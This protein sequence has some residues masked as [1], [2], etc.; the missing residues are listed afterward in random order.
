[1][2][3]GN[4][5][6][7]TVDQWRGDCLS[8]L[9]HP[10]VETPNLDRLAAG[11]TVFANHWAQSAPCGPSRAC[12]YT[13]TYSMTN[14]VL[15][16]GTPLDARFTNLAVEARAGGYDPVLVG[17]TD[18]S[19]DPRGLAPDDPRLFS[20]E[21][22]LPGFEAVVDLRSQTLRPWIGWLVELGYERPADVADIYAADPTVA[23]AA[24]HGP[25]WAPPVYRAEHSDTAFL[26]DGLMEWLAARSGVDPL[27]RPPQLPATPSAVPGAGAVPRSL[28]SRG[29]GL[30]GSST[31]T[32]PGAVAP[33]V[34]HGPRRARH[35][36]PRR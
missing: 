32:R 18:V 35:P 2:T 34:G 26:T 5:L 3:P 12:L 31:V 11:G 20:Y 8:V 6:L 9:G 24:D 36:G 17:Y 29:R 27:V 13:G 4:V 14:R 22:V 33:A 7:V 10:V 23:G 28:S 1:M 21:G 16:N 15:A 25:S 30:P 19:V